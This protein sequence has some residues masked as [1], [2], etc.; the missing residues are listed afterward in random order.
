MQSN[1]ENTGIGREQTKSQKTPEDGEEEA[2]D[3][4]KEEQASREENKESVKCPAA[5]RTHSHYQAAADEDAQVNKEAEDHFSIQM[6]QRMF[7]ESGQDGRSVL[8][9]LA[10]QVE[11]DPKTGATVVK[12]VAPMS[13]SADAP[14]VTTV[15][16]DGRKSIHAVG[17]TGCQPSTEELGQILSAIDGVGMTALLEEVTVVPSRDAEMKI[18]IVE[19]RRTPEEKV[20]SFPTHHAMSKETDTQLDS[21]GS[22]DLEAELSAEDCAV[23][24]GNQEDKQEDRCITAVRDIAG[25]VENVED[26]RLEEGPVTLLFLG[27]ADATTS[28]GHSQEDDEGM[29]TVERVIITEDGE[30]HVLGPETSAS[31]PSSLDKVAEQEAGKESPAEV[32]QVI[33][34]DGNGAGVKVQ[35]EE[36]DKEQ[37]RSSSPSTAVGEGTSKRKTCQCCSIM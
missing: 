20:V 28:Q 18:E 27:Y 17:G 10:V 2:A 34:L 30:E 32:F 3:A 14:K 29:L 21:T 23:I 33:P 4:R 1:Q 7:H 5:A 11:R 9:M 13:T 12:S 26:Q 24:V 37:Q 15:F 6:A 16:D 8:G 19:A 25:E 31:P 35:G 22:Y 36:G